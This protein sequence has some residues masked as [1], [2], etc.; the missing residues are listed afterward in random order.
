MGNI[1][2]LKKS[3]GCLVLMALTTP[4]MSQDRPAFQKGP[5]FTDY[6]EYTPVEFDMPIPEGTEFHIAFDVTDGTEPGQINRSINTPA[7]FI[8]MHVNAGVPLENIH[9]AV[10]VHGKG[11]VDLL[12][13]AAYAKRHPGMT[14]ANRPLVETL[15]QHNVRFI[16]CGQSAAGLGISRDEL[17][18]GVEF[19]LSAI[20]AHALLQQQ[21]YTLNPF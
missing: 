5:V 14:N 4:A 20:T 16:I 17:I 21:G 6:G 9:L 15:L 12:S 3:L 8:N 18:P 10:V 13:D 1:G 19:A 11:G 2:V 7:R